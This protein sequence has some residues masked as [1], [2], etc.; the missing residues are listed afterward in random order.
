ML[1]IELF[2]SRILETFL[3]Q[4]RSQSASEKE[5]T[6]QEYLKIVA[7]NYDDAE[8]I[9]QDKEGYFNAGVA[10][11][12]LDQEQVEDDDQW[13]RKK[14]KKELIF[15]DFYKFQRKAANDKKG[16]DRKYND[17]AEK[18]DEGLEEDEESFGDFINPLSDNDLANDDK[19]PENGL[20]DMDYLK[21]RKQALA[22]SFQEQLASLNKKKLKVL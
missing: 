21:K 13:K 1:D 15:E 8:L 6:L 11:G 5:A 12:K 22:N 16:I 7:D 14:K 9:L 19:I 20:D 18:Q 10:Y 2:Q 17:L 3:P 4:F